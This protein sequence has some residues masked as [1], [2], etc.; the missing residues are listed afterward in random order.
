MFHA[1]DLRWVLFGKMQVQR[2]SIEGMRNMKRL[3]G[4]GVCRCGEK[5]RCDSGTSTDGPYG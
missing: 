1:E 3:I 2:T 5:D 4:E